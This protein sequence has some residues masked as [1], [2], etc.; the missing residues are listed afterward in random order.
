ML[1]QLPVGSQFQAV[2]SR[3]VGAFEADQH[4][5][6]SG[7]MGKGNQLGIFREADIR[8]RE[9]SN[10]LGNQS[11][12]QFLRI[13]F[14]NKSIVV[15]KFNEGARPERFDAANFFNYFGDGLR[16]VTW[17][18]QDGARTKVALP[19]T[20]ARGLHGDT[21]IFG[22]IKQVKTRDGRVTKVPRA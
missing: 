19:G 16:L 18:D 4:L 7:I 17:C 13:A 14:V 8:F 22:R 1:L 21:I 3:E 11:T 5:L 2:E 15:G 6:A 20:T 12:H 10:A 9:E